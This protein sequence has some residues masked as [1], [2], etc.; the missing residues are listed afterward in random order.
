[1]WRDPL[2][3]KEK[4][5]DRVVRKRIDKDV[6]PACNMLRRLAVILFVLA[7]DALS[8]EEWTKVVQRGEG[9][10]WEGDDWQHAVSCC[11]CKTCDER[12]P[13]SRRRPVAARELRRV[14]DVRASTSATAAI[15]AGPGS[16]GVA[17]GAR[18]ST[19]RTPGRSDVVRA[20]RTART[21]TSAARSDPG[22]SDHIPPPNPRLPR[23]SSRRCRV[24]RGERITRNEWL[25]GSLEARTRGVK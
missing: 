22:R 15:R 7:V 25:A 2:R 24:H 1:M 14:R 16:T 10:W 21:A 4:S 11:G 12:G 13:A 8:K 6:P 17:P 18:T 5:C 23:G 9:C 19:T 3:A 20:T